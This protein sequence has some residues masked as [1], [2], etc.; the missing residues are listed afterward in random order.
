MRFANKIAVVTGGASGIGHAVAAGLS[1]DGAT[2]I[3]FD[4]NPG[5]SAEAVKRITDA[6]GR[7]ESLLV[8]V[9]RVDQIK[10]AFT[11]VVQRHRRLDILVNAAG[12]GIGKPIGEYTE[13]EW[14]RQMA[15]NVKGTFF[16]MQQAVALMAPHKHGKV[17]NFC[18][19]SAFVAS[20]KPAIAYDTSKGAVRLMTISAGAELAAEGINVNAVAPGTT[21]TEM[22]KGM[23]DTDEGMRWQTDRIP[24]GRVAQPVDIAE[25]VLFLCSS[26]ADYM[27]GHVLVVD[28]GWTLF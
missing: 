27:T 15:V 1:R 5:L 8:D 23:L 10:K 12:I 7:A 13:A 18:S 16:C 22:T 6:K 24:M 2:T 28:G 4:V 17:V 19:T 9:T 3:I 26:A 21:Y 11:E 25:P 14:D 20:S